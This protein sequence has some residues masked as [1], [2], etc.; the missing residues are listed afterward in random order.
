MEGEKRVGAWGGE[1]RELWT[2][3]NCI[4]TELCECMYESVGA[5]LCG[6]VYMSQA[7]CM[8][9]SH[10]LLSSRRQHSPGRTSLERKHIFGASQPLGLWEGWT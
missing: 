5:W 7:C 3:V 4:T 6:C 1:G 8:L 10:V 2:R 9:N